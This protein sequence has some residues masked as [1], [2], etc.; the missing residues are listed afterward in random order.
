MVEAPL[1]GASGSD[2]SSDSFDPLTLSDTGGLLFVTY[3]AYEAG[4]SPAYMALFDVGGPLTRG[5]VWVN[6][7]TGAGLPSAAAFA[8]VK[9]ETRLVTLVPGTRALQVRDVTSGN[10]TRSTTFYTGACDW[11]A[12]L[13][14]EVGVSSP[15][16][17]VL[18]PDDTFHKPTL[19]GVD[20]TTGGVV[21]SVTVPALALYFPPPLSYWSSAGLLLGLTPTRLW[22]LH[23]SNGTVVWRVYT[24]QV[25]I[26]TLPAYAHGAGAAARGGKEE[27]GAAA[28]ASTP[29]LYILGS[30]G[31]RRVACTS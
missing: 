17:W 1:P 20:L 16:A 30:A 21:F 6:T 29:L 28:P 10:V 12:A 15:R 9:G 25:Y 26:S 11:R 3:S 14:V 4:G 2:V 22:A 19:S 27:E 13:V 8:R 5:P 18:C 23:P 31:G 24:P 7:L